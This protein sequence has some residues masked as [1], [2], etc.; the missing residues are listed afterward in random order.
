MVKEAVQGKFKGTRSLKSKVTPRYPESAE[1]EFK[2]VANG[3]M[4][5]LNQTLKEHLPAIMDAYKKAQRKDSRYDGMN[6]L[7][8]KVRQEFQK[9]AEK[10]EKRLGDY[11]IHNL[12]ERIGRLTKT[13]SLRE[14]KRVC[15]EALG[16]DLAE[17]YYNGDFYEEAL[18]RWVD[19]NVLKIKSIPN[20]SL[21]TM[22]EIVLSGFQKGRT[23]TDISK[24]IQAEYKVSKEKALMLARDQIGTLNS[25]IS[26]LQQQDAGCTKYRWKT[27]HDSRVR[28]CHQS[29]DGKIFSWD[30]PPEI[31]YKTKTRGIVHTG[32]RCHPGEDYCC[33]CAAI[34][35]F[36]INTINVPM[37]KAVK[38]KG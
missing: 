29:F 16:I 19:E 26:K 24:E 27:V 7:A 28:D 32:R 14:W 33:R 6:D 12:V 1:R 30:D 21:G 10:L 37:E 13:S 34:P 8:S 25:Q 18:R 17:D 31:W 36:D 11:G 20:D 22:R 35:V 9:I 5:L 15:K 4:K 38:I 2:R 23:I 3:Y